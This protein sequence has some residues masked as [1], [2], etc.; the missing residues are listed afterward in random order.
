MILAYARQCQFEQEHSQQVTRLALRLFDELASVHGL[1]SA[2]R[3]LLQ[4][5]G[6]LHDIG[7]IDGQK[8]HHKASRD[9]ILRE[10]MLPLEQRDRVVVALI[11]RYHR[12]ALPRPDHKHF[13]SLPTQEQ[14]R[15]GILAGL[16]RVAD[17]LDRSH[18]DLVTDLRCEASDSVIRV[19]AVC[20]EDAEDE[21][22]AARKKADL[23]AR[24][25]GRRV[26]VLAEKT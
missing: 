9:M 4:Y 16:L 19:V 24:A 6:L 11:A 2:D 21:I 18:G 1:G 14:A 3:E 7:W 20:N 5:G 8:G 26:E 17:G 13:A 23:L 15:V 10:P 25:L 22:W 12:K